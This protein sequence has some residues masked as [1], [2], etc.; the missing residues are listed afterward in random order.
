MLTVFKIRLMYNGRLEAWIDDEL[1]KENICDDAA[2]LFDSINT[3]FNSITNFRPG[4]SYCIADTGR[5]KCI[6]INVNAQT[7]FI[8]QFRATFL[9]YDAEIEGVN[10]RCGQLVTNLK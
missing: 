5:R 7:A 6:S 1:S 3:V 2:N 4:F 10:V 9:I 8:S